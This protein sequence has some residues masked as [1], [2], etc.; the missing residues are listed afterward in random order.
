MGSLNPEYCIIIP[1]YNGASGLPELLDILSDLPG[2]SAE[3]VLVDDGSMDDTWDVI[4]RNARTRIRGIKLDRN[5]GQQSAI[6]A[7][8]TT[9]LNKPV[10]TMD[11]DCS[12]PL[13]A[14]PHLLKALNKG[15]DL[16]YALPPRRPGS[17]PRRIVS[18]LHQYH[19]S[20]I[21]GSS[22]SLQ[23]GSFRGMSPGIINRILTEPLIFPYI[24]AQALSLR[25]A[26][27]VM[28]I[29][30][31]S[32]NPGHPGRLSLLSLLKIEWKLAAAYGP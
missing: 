8:L 31:P 19:M 23:V 3:I 4:C 20:F 13:P 30:S 29:D 24:S 25:P 21:T 5:R 18:R 32:F 27:S 9:C 1:V 16:A 11:D 7:A 17:A 26:P 12:H 28:M 2:P 6:L 22:F 14:I 10:I 15:I